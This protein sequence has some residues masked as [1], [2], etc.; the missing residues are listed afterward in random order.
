MHSRCKFQWSMLQVNTLF[1]CE[2]DPIMTHDDTYD[3]TYISSYYLIKDSMS[4]VA[5]KSLDKTTWALYP[6]ELCQG[7]MFIGIRAVG[8][9]AGGNYPDWIL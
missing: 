2:N 7:M 4:F 9:S 3:D 5:V 8:T 1:S 6:C